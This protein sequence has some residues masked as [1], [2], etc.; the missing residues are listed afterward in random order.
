MRFLTSALFMVLGAAG[1]R[2]ASSTV[3]YPVEWLSAHLQSAQEFRPYATVLDR[4]AWTSVDEAN[5]TELISLAVQQ[6]SVPWE[7][8]P[9]TRFLDYVRDGDRSRYQA[10]YFNRRQR[11]RVFCLAEC[12]EGK[13]RFLDEVVNGLWLL[14]EESSWALPAHLSNQ[15]GG[16]GLPDVTDPT[17]DLFA[18]ETGAQLAWTYYLLGPVIDWVSP[19]IGS[20]IQME[21][22]RRI[23]DPFLTREDYPWMGL[24]TQRKL[25]NWSPWIVSNVLACAFLVER[26]ESRRVQ[27]TSRCL[28][29]LDRYLA[30]QTSDGCCEEGPG[31]WNNS[32]GSAFDA[33][34]LLYLATDG[35]LNGF[36]G[37]LAAMAAYIYKAQAADRWFMNFSDAPAKPD[38]DGPMCYRFGQRIGDADLVQFGAWFA[39]RDKRLGAGRMASMGRLI[40]AL[41]RSGEMNHAVASLP[42]LRNA[43]WP[44][45][46]VMAVRSTGGSDQGL[47]LAAKGG[48][49]AESHNHNDIGSCI[50]F[51]DGRPVLIDSGPGSYTRETFGANRYD[52]WTMQ[53]AFHNLPSI[54][55]FMQSPGADFRATTVSFN[56]DVSRTTFVLDI[57]NAYPP[58]AQVKKWIRQYKFLSAENRIGIEDEYVLSSAD[59]PSQWHF[60]LPVRPHLQGSGR[61]ILY[62]ESEHPVV[63]AFDPELEAEIMAVDTSDPPLQRV[64]GSQIFRLTLTQ[65]KLH[66]HGRFR[67]EIQ[68]EQGMTAKPRSNEGR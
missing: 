59:R 38:I 12:I 34:E 52:I 1:L 20:R 39:Q 17:L 8:L 18:A 29:I 22:E 53:S 3:A 42:L 10:L 23:L 63:L 5:R 27:L 9:A 60:L 68:L 6:L 61:A 16:P 50:V 31:Y 58:D 21:I 64:W 30:T 32:A 43:W 36:H 49:N 25:N 41:L 51:A 62:R 46:Q 37:K 47:Y 2:S 26:E 56:S 66:L 44:D 13:G 54:N 28:A 24:G 67:L 7:V 19:L 33:L 65:P 45:L 48:N 55:G 14:C 57:A 4:T 11:G 40:P 15:R 35:E